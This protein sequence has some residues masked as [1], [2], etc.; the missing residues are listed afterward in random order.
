MEPYQAW[1]VEEVAGHYWSLRAVPL[2]WRLEKVEMIVDL[3][4]VLHTSPP[5]HGITGDLLEVGGLVP[6]WVEVY[7][8]FAVAVEV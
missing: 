4:R 1:V 7:R 5:D 3:L 6:V 2:Y 8:T